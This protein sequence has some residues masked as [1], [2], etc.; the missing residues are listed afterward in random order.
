LHPTGPDVAK[1]ITKVTDSSWGDNVTLGIHIPTNE[2]GLKQ[3]EMKVRVLVVALVKER[4]KPLGIGKTN[5]WS[6]WVIDF[7]VVQFFQGKFCTK[8]SDLPAHISNFE[9]IDLLL[10]TE[11]LLGC[12][13]EIK[14]SGPEACR[15]LYDLIRLEMLGLYLLGSVTA[16]IM[17]TADLQWCVCWPVVEVDL[18]PATKR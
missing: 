7:D 4:L 2:E 11:C 8:F 10:G 18:D 1:K 9:R 13:N 17:H 14:Y 6:V 15:R 12:A 3:I 5:E 16:S